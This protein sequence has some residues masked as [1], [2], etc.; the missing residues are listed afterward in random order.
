MALRTF[1]AIIS[2]KNLSDARYCAGMDVD[3]IGFNVNPKSEA[4]VSPDKF[5]EITEWISGVEYIGEFDGKHLDKPHIDNYPVNYILITSP[6]LAFDITDKKVM[7]ASGL[8]DAIKLDPALPLEYLIVYSDN[9]QL[10]DE[11]IKAMAGLSK[12]FNVLIGSGV[13]PDNI[14]KLLIATRARGIA[15]QGGDEIR[16]GYKDYDALADVL[17]ELEIDDL[18]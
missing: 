11:Q 8:E 2:V 7:L 13:A 9:E 15:L 18:V 1:V 10:S 3:L 17:E 4:Y 5:K 16:P 6:E 12:H 14:D